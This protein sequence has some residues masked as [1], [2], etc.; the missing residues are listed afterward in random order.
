MSGRY[1][2]K[3]HMN[4]CSGVMVVVCAPLLASSV[5]PVSLIWFDFSPKVV[6][7]AQPETASTIPAA[8][9]AAASIGTRRVIRCNKDCDV[10]WVTRISVLNLFEQ[11]Y[12]NAIS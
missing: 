4:F 2:E 7:E 8:A 6:F 5:R 10:A 3:N 11:K 12:Q 9:A 1:G